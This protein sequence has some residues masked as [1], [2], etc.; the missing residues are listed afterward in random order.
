M[1]V[2]ASRLVTVAPPAQMLSNFSRLHTYPGA[3]RLPSHSR[4]FSTGAGQRQLHMLCMNCIGAGLCTPFVLT[5][6]YGG[7][8][9]R[10]VFYQAIVHLWLIPF[11][12]LP[13][14]STLVGT[15]VLGPL[16][17]HLDWRSVKDTGV[18]LKWSELLVRQAG[19]VLA[20]VG[21]M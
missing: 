5:I 6:F 17:L 14:S 21:G 19:C 4:P 9:V 16:Y 2:R 18:T 15:V 7:C 10:D 3:S 8:G 12:D 13:V 20:W 1:P 11:I